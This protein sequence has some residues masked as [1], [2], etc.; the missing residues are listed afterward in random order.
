VRPPSRNSFGGTVKRIVKAPGERRRELL[1][2]AEEL[3]FA[4]GYESTSVEEIIGA[5][6]V[7]KGA[8][9]HYFESKEALLEALADRLV[10]QN[11]RESSTVLEEPFPGSLARLNAFMSDSRRMNIVAAPAVRRTLR[12]IFRPENLPL[13]HRINAATIAKV[14]PVL[15]A[16]LEEG[17]AEGVFDTPDP[18]GTAEMLLHIGT[19]VH[20]TIARAIDASERADY[21]AAEEMLEQRLALYEIAFNRVLGLPDHAVSLVEPGFAGAVLAR[22]ASEPAVDRGPRER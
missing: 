19:S 10:D 17:V 9:Y 15:A 12:V 1:D 4:R 16:I 3:F 21:D 5:A 2:R 7:S 20:D 22:G 11:L 13:R 8:F 6:G 18:L 14:A